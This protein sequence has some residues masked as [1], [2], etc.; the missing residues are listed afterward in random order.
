M[1]MTVVVPATTVAQRRSALLHLVLLLMCEDLLWSARKAP[2]WSPLVTWHAYDGATAGFAGPGL[3]YALPT[4]G[5]SRDHQAAADDADQAG[6]VNGRR[7]AAI[8]GG[9]QGAGAQRRGLGRP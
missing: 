8:E 2:R 1:R 3:V 6:A 7:R 9:Y 4:S 5:R